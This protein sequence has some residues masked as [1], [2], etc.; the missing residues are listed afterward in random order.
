MPA[1]K[2]V[3][4]KFTKKPVKKVKTPGSF[5]L[6]NKLLTLR[7]WSRTYTTSLFTK[8]IKDYNLVC[9]YPLGNFNLSI[10]RD[11]SSIQTYLKT[12]GKLY[13]ARLKLINATID[14]QMITISFQLHNI[15]LKASHDMEFATPVVIFE[16]ILAD[17]KFFIYNG[18]KLDG[19]IKP[20]GIIRKL[21]E[22]DPSLRRRTIEYL[23]F[24]LGDET[25][26][27]SSIDWRKL[28]G[29]ND[30]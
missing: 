27:L 2:K 13:I 26:Q 22:T 6:K 30:R 15:R 18:K 8:K 1:K 25:E 10:L 16:E 7:F 5:L 12:R 11:T 9:Q 4:K 20:L 3:I 21:G 24:K 17:K 28:R 14:P 23:N 29:E 19:Y